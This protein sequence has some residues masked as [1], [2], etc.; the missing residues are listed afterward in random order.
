MSEHSLHE[1]VRRTSFK[2]GHWG[3]QHVVACLASLLAALPLLDHVNVYA[4]TSL[5]GVVCL[6]A[7]MAGSAGQRQAGVDDTPQGRT[8]SL[9][10]E[11]AQPEQLGMLL[12]NVLPVWRQHVGSVRQQ[13]DD[14]VTGL[15]TSFS[16]ITEQFDKAGFKG[17]DA[18]ADRD[19]D[20]VISLLKLCER[21]LEPVIATMMR[22][23][24]S[25]G[26]MSASVQQLAKMT[27]EL[28]VMSSGVGQIAS[29]TNLL[30]INAAIEAARVGE[31]GR[32][33]AVIA[34][35]IRSL[36]E[37]SA[38]TAKKIT[39]S[40]ANVTETMTV[41]TAAADKA[42]K[43]DNIAI[44]LSGTVIKDVLTHVC[45]LSEDSKKMLTSGNVIRSSIE[46]LIV[47]LQFQDRVNQVIG[48]I[49]NDM[50][51]LKEV[52]QGGEQPPDPQQWLADLQGHYTMR[53]QRQS[54]IEAGARGPAA[55]SG[56]AETKVVFF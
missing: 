24:D 11:A 53:D 30:A 14:A 45:A 12:S 54:H 56:K 55:Q 31:A 19:E 33:F 13:T 50:T 52:I 35:E 32:G 10:S 20:T 1:A 41:T 28:E 3:A 51:R 44:Q 8:P 2:P 40:V 36:S 17:T 43:D 15:I 37:S 49:D 26:A 46:A 25:K 29:Q 7:W 16:S 23:A 21:E 48:V 6:T 9:G 27:R 4:V 18:R 39:A 34:K 47:G 5:I 22:I 42:A 38:Q